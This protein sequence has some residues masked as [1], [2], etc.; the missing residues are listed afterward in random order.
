MIAIF[1]HQHMCQEAGA[2]HSLGDGPL[3]RRCLV[4][5][6]AGAAAVF[7]PANAQDPKPRRNKVEHLAHGLAD[8]MKGAAAARTKSAL[9]VDRHVLA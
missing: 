2:R 7:G 9:N 8:H 3:R 6:T 5:R 1:A 4:D